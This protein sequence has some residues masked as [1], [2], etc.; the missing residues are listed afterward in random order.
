MSVTLLVPTLDEEKALPELIEAFDKLDPRPQEILLVDGGSCDR[1]IDMAREAGWRILECD[2]GRA[3]QINLGVDRAMGEIVCVVH[4]DTIPPSDM[5]RVIEDTLA[6]R[7]IALASF[8]PIIRGTEKTR[9]VTTVHNWAKTWYAPL[10]TRPH[11]F[12]RG[13]RLLFGDHVMFFRR[14]D[15]L[16]VGGCTPGD[17]VMEEADLC[18]KLAALGRVKMVLR[19]VSTSDR[20]I[21]AWGPVK[22]NWIYFKVGMLWAIGLRHRMAENYPDVR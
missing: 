11:L 6:D 13:V 5:V 9:W 14:S 21:V 12:F 17:A 20:R 1:T 3:R 15:F 8:T 19:C 22:A 16:R 7:R 4:A 2:T 18:V 10:I